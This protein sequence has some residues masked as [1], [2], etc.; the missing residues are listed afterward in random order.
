MSK[1]F[2][3]TTC[4][5]ISHS[6]VMVVI[7]L[8]EQRT[9][10][11]ST[12]RSPTSHMP[13]LLSTSRPDMASTENKRWETSYAKPTRSASHWSYKVCYLLYYTTFSP[14]RH[15]A[16]DF[17]H[18]TIFV[19]FKWGTWNSYAIRFIC[20]V[21]KNRSMHACETRKILALSHAMKLNLILFFQHV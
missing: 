15:L 11:A 13:L 8:S 21:F 3:T 19:L 16:V 18:H 17:F 10:E 6:N 1:S 12:N 14:F 4:S 5:S 7:C 9:W 20:K 2:E